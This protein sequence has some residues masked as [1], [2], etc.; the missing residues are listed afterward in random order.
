MVGRSDSEQPKD[1]REGR[2]GV[3]RYVV[4]YLV[5]AL[6]IGIAVWGT[7]PMRS[8][9]KGGKDC[10][11]NLLVQGFQAGQ[12]N[13]KK[14]PP[15]GFVQLADPY[16][17]A[18]NGAYVQDLRGMSYYNGK[19]Y[20]YFGIAPVLFLYWPSVELT[21]HY[22]TD[23]VAALDFCMTGFLAGAG[24]I[25]AIWRH[26]FPK[27]GTWAAMA[28]ILIF[29]LTVDAQEIEWA[30]SIVSEVASSS[31]FAFMMIALAALWLALRAPKGR[32]LWLLLASLAYGL[33]INSRPSLLPGAAILLLPLA[34][35]WKG[36]TGLRP[37]AGWLL[38]GAVGPITLIGLGMLFY[39]FLRFSNPLEF[40]YRYQLTYLDQTAVARFS[41]HYF[42]FDLRYY[43]LEPPRW[44]GHLPF[45]TTAQEWASSWGHFD[46]KPYYGGI[47]FV[48]FPPLW[49]ALGIIC[50]R[51]ANLTD[52]LVA[53]RWFVAALFLV[54]AT[55]ALTLCFFLYAANRY[56]MDFLPALMLL[57]VIGLLCVSHAPP[58]SPRWRHI[59]R[60]CSV[61]MVVYWLVTN[62]C[63]SCNAYAMA[64]YLAGNTQSNRGH[65]DEARHL[66]ERAMAFAPQDTDAHL[67]LGNLSYS[68]G[69]IDGAIAQYQMALKQRPNF[70]EAHNYL[71][72]CF[73]HGGQ[74]DSAISE[75][76]AAAQIKPDYAEA[77]SNL[78]YCLHQKGR[79]DQ[80][81][82]QYQKAIQIQPDQLGAGAYFDLG[83]A[84]RQKGMAAQAMNSYRKALKLAPGFSPARLN[85]AWML[86]TW[87][88][89]GIR[90]GDEA[91]GL[92]QKANGL[93]G[94]QNPRVLR[95]L[96]AAYAE[97]GHFPEAITTAHQAA[98]GAPSRTNLLSEIE[99]DIKL[100][101]NH[102]PCRSK[103][104]F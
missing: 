59:V 26:S 35:E 12:L 49:L 3:T 84:Y 23:D 10:Y 56:E 88:D 75:F 37:R 29:G 32:V 66:F 15:A 52:E 36:M 77:L 19:L 30:G 90:N 64:N 98:A 40:G 14:D 16:D 13:M 104:G 82:E 76:E 54:F 27:A 25:F 89:P 83:N 44:T 74:L 91:L 17:P 31:A 51:K 41:P 39:N 65:T 55:G 71:G 85:L 80:A 53:L 4:F 93:S 87:P 20:L 22:L 5:C 34:Q 58:S 96:A 24:L 42:W 100:Y 6:V 45:L 48:T 73:L 1:R 79:L 11:F 28:G 62:T 43:F 61:L 9:S 67:G 92:T 103:A 7:E 95:I 46:P 33:A 38:A 78:G 86:A 60:F 97:T 50:A 8:A 102:S 101:Q 72:Y 57:S 81:I 99:S 70:P 2:A 18:H 63:A 94:G 21:G 68:K 47:L 69:D